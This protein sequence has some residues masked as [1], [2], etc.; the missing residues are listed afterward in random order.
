MI[1]SEDAP[2]LEQQLHRHFVFT[3]MNKVNHRKEFFRVSLKEIREEIEELGLTTGVHW[4]MTANAKCYRESLA[5]EKAI[6]DN[7]AMREAWLKRQLD[8]EFSGDG[9]AED[10]SSELVETGAE[11]D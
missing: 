11:E 5:I 9:I 7:P 8:M 2:A 4:T 3:Q 6:K 1:L 10:E